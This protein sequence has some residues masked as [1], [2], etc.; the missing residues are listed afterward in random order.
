MMQSA[1]VAAGVVATA[2]DS[3]KDPQFAAYDF[4]HEMEHPETGKLRTY[5]GPL[6]RMSKLSY[7]MGRPPMLGEHNDYVY[8]KLLGIPDEE[9][10]RLMEEDVI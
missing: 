10:V 5:H 9:F 2:E 4:F 7:E 3:E 6:F 1:G 8:T